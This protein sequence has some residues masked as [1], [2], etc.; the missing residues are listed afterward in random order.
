MTK[1]IYLLLNDKDPGSA[2]AALG[3][4]EP[5][6]TIKLPVPSKGKSLPIPKTKVITPKEEVD[7]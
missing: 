3:P 1:V 4:A 6:P 2:F 7:I 5:K